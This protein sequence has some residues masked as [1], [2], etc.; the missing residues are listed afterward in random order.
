MQGPGDCQPKDHEHR[1]HNQ[2]P[3]PCGGTQQRKSQDPGL[4]QDLGLDVGL[5]V[6]HR[7][8]RVI[9]WQ[10]EA[11]SEVIDLSQRGLRWPARRAQPGDLQSHLLRRNLGGH[12]PQKPFLILFAKRNLDHL[13]ASPAD[14]EREAPVAPVMSAGDKGGARFQPVHHAFLH[15]IVQGAIDGRWM[16][17]PRFPD[18]VENGVGAHRLARRAQT[19]QDLALIG[20]ELWRRAFMDMMMGRAHKDDI[21]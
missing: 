1:G 20:R 11:L 10:G 3:L 19:P 5:G 2:E 13:V 7:E 6:P 15:Q 16:R 18:P 8:Q 4:G 14:G 9:Q 21:T 17:N 12:E